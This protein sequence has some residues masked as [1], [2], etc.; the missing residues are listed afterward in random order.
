MTDKEIAEYFKSKLTKICMNKV[1][2]GLGIPEKERK[3]ILRED[4]SKMVDEAREKGLSYIYVDP[5]N[6]DYPLGPLK[7]AEPRYKYVFERD[8][9]LTEEEYN[10]LFNEKGE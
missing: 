9:K 6:P 7:L 10:N 1:S 8:F 2:T 3:L 4:L 5:I